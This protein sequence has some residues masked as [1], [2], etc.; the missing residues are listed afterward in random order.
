MSK[1]YYTKEGLVYNC[2]GKTHNYFYSGGYKPQIQVSCLQI[3]EKLQFLFEINLQVHQFS[4]FNLNLPDKIYF[5]LQQVLCFDDEY[6]SHFN[7]LQYETLVNID[8]TNSLIKYSEEKSELIFEYETI[9]L[10]VSKPFN[11]VFNSNTNEDIQ[12][13]INFNE[14]DLKFLVFSD[15]EEHEHP[16]LFMSEEQIV[17]NNKC[18]DEF[19]SKIIKVFADF[20]YNISDCKDLVRLIDIR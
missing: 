12:N 2:V 1:I 14:I 17:S 9:I 20:G 11:Y 13:D 5:Q 7:L 19:F 16:L 18:L 10:H 15:P 3:L 4:F 6:F 8:R